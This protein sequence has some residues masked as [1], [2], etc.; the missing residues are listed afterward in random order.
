MTQTEVRLV[1]PTAVAVGTA[2][3]EEVINGKG[4]HALGIMGSSSGSS[5]YFLLLVCSLSLK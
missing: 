3:V 1:E 2:A 5:V 4:S